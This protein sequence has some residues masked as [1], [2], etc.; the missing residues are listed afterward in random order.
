MKIVLA[1]WHGRV[2]HLPPKLNVKNINYE[3]LISDLV[4]LYETLATNLTGMGI[5]WKLV[6][7]DIRS[8]TF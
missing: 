1:T 2:I 3:K 7:K 6:K 4:P 5:V 8:Q